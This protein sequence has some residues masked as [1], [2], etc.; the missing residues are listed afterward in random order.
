M[1]ECSVP[2]GHTASLGN[3]FPTFRKIRSRFISRCLN[4]MISWRCPWIPAITEACRKKRL[5]LK[6][7]ATLYTAT[8]AHIQLHGVTSRIKYPIFRYCLLKMFSI[9]LRYNELQMMIVVLQINQQV[10]T[11]SKVYYLTFTY[12]STCFGR[13]HAHHQELYNCSSR[14]WYYRWSVVIAVLLVVIGPAGPTTTSST[15]ITTLRR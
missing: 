2:L 9:W 7:V 6:T 11:I 5:E 13:S 4:V 3:R 10:A 12:S 8:L 14:L 1:A 15:A